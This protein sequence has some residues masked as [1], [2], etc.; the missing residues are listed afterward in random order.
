MEHLL[1]GDLVV[2]RDVVDAY[3]SDEQSPELDLDGLAMR[4]VATFE[5]GGSRCLPGDLA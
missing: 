3:E 4:A 5:V 1:L 2:V